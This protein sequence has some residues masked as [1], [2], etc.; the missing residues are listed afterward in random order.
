MIELKKK[1][2]QKQQKKKVLLIQNRMIFVS[3][4]FILVT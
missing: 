3:T 2:I 4:Q 1:Q